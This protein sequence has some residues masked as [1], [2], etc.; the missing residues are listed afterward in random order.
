MGK[1]SREN[2]T[3]EKRNMHRERK[4]RK[5]Q[6]RS[7]EKGRTLA[8]ELQKEKDRLARQRQVYECL[9]RNYYDRLRSILKRKDEEASRKTDRSI[10]RNLKAQIKVRI[11]FCNLVITCL[12]NY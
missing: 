8:L 9:S 4:K 6:Q 12:D 1:K 2:T 11:Q 3:E 5:R 7:L 10:Y